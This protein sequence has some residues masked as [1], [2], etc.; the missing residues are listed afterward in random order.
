MYLIDR[1]GSMSQH[2]AWNLARR[3]LLVS[4]APLPPDSRFGLIFY[5]LET[6]PLP[7]PDGSSA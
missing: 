5:D 1:S 6:E 3:E 4:L 7:R 2:D